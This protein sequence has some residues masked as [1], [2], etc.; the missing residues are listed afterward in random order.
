VGQPYTSGG[1]GLY[2]I[3]VSDRSATDDFRIVGPGVNVLVTGR[4]FV[5]AHTVSLSLRPGTYRYRSDAHP[6][7]R[8]SFVVA[9]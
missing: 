7:V 3:T 8:G 6:T 5:G 9:G 4:H 2:V 1:P